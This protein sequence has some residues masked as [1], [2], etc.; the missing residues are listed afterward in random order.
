MNK[1]EYL[2][3]LREV[4]NCDWDSCTITRAAYQGNLA[5]VKYGVENGCPMD[6]NACTYA[7]KEGHL[8]V[9]KYLHEND[10]PWNSGACFCA[11]KYNRIDC[12]NYLIEQKCPGFEEYLPPAAAAQAVAQ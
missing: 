8:D 10:C 7:A 9:L 6:T 1:L 3:W 11:H 12:L 4:K 2:V 5:M